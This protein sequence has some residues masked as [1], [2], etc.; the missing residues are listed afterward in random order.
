MKP[1]ALFQHSAYAEP[2]YVTDYLDGQGIPWVLHRIDLGHAVPA[3]PTAYA[4]LC[5]LGGSMSVNDPL[6]WIAEELALARAAD[7]LDIP[8]VGHC[9]GSQLIARAFG[10]SVARNRVKEIGWGWLAPHASQSARDWLG[11]ASRLRSFQW[12][13]D[14]FEVPADAELF[15]SSE[16]CAHQTFVIR[17][18]HLGMQSHLEMTPELLRK[19]IAKGAGEIEREIALHGTAAVQAADEML[20]G[21]DAKCAEVNATMRRLYDRWIVKLQA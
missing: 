1:V 13:A 10:A 9:F 11:D 8:M 21:A 2:G 7:R 19:L 14:T 12:H 4:G 3:D 16:F 18:I 17:D 20:D 6:A 15:M 5:F